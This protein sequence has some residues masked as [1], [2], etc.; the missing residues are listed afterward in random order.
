M[1]TCLAV[2]AT[3]PLGTAADTSGNT[4]GCRASRANAAA[5]NPTAQCPQAG[6]G[7]AG[8]CGSNCQ[9][10]CQIVVASCTGANQ[11]YAS[12]AAC[13]TACAGFTDNVAFNASVQTGNTLACRLYHS[14]ETTQDPAT[15]CPHTAANSPTCM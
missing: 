8:T 4:V 9:G 1:G 2:C 14:T 13:M 10:F 3:I 6:P 7:G 5:A 11:Q 12:S 15:H